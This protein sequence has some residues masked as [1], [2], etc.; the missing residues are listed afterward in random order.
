M[1]VMTTP[2]SGMLSVGT[3]KDSIMKFWV[4]VGVLKPKEDSYR[5]I[6]LSLGQ[7]KKNDFRWEKVELG[8]RGKNFQKIRILK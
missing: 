8:L 2:L 6:I 4:G 7:L 3:T 5:Q 1:N